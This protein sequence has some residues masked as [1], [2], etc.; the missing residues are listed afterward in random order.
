MTDIM[1]KNKDIPEHIRHHFGIKKSRE[2]LLAILMYGLRKRYASGIA[3]KIH[4]TAGMCTTILR[5]FEK[6]GLIIFKP[7][8]KKIKEIILTDKGR[9]IAHALLQLD[10]E[11]REL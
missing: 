8:N 9:K 7:A 3:K 2:L 1:K 11:L 5:K 10:N 4:M 6:E